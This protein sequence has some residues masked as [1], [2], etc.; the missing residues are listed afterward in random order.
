MAVV[1][2]SHMTARAAEQGVTLI[3]HFEGPASRTVIDVARDL[4]PR[5]VVSMFDLD[6][7]TTAWLEEREI[8]VASMFGAG[9]A[10]TVSDRSGW[11]Q[12]KHLAGL[13]HTKIAFADTTEDG[14]Q[15][16]AT[17]RY[18]GI[19]DA[20]HEEGLAAPVRE[21]FALDG[22]DAG[23][24][25]RSWVDAGVTAVAAYNDEVAIAVLAGIRR[26]GLRCPQDLAVIG[27]DEM[28]INGAMEPPLSSIAFDHGLMAS[29]YADA[30]MAILDGNAEPRRTI[31]TEDFIRV[32]PRDSTV[33]SGPA[34]RQVVDRSSNPVDNSEPANRVP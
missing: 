31:S 9:R 24:T 34:I 4:R 28:A 29:R 12:V 32:V 20:C 19:T 21:A 33:S 5:V 25:V 22:S 15:V 6:D 7:E 30:L 26:A 1:S 18:R 17:M 8:T 10:M 13:G 2:S 11:V 16:L 23:E 14:L 3:V 27:V